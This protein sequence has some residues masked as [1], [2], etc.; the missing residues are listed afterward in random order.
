MKSFLKRLF[1]G[2]A[3]GVGAAIPGVSGAAV[4]LIFRI[5]EDLINA[6]NS[7]RTHIKDSIVILLPILLGII[8]AVIPCIYLFSL[9]FE[10]LMFVLISM[11]VGFLVGSLPSVTDE[12][13]GIKPTKKY[14]AIFIIAIIFVALMGIGSV[15]LGPKID[16]DAQFTAMPLWMYFILIPVGI[17]AAVAL[18]VPGLSG[19]LILLVIGFYRPLVDHARLWA[20]DIVKTGDWSNFGKLIGMVGC[21]AIGCIIGV[22]LISKLMRMLL[23]RYHDGTYVAITG[24]IIGSIFAL[25]FNYEIYNYYLNWAGVSHVG[26]EINP[27]MPIYVEIPLGIVITILCAF[28]SYQIVRYQRKLKNEQN[29]NE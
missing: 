26:A 21:F 22:V 1:A 10:H 25:Y 3:I 9:A 29:T 13:K 16:L 17:L 24:F 19:S 11:F 28:G 18:S 8:L 15:F 7:F 5:Y 23:D 14:V 20:G 4:A 12:I 2:M 6:I 27:I